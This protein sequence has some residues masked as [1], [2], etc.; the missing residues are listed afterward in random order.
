MRRFGLLA[1]LVCL[2]VPAAQAAPITIAFT[3][4]VTKDPF[5]F[6]SLGA[7]ISGTYTYDPA[8]PDTDAAVS[9]G[10]YTSVGSLYGFHVVV[11]GI[12]FNVAGSVEIDVSNDTGGDAYGVITTLDDLT[13]VLTFV[14]FTQSALSSDALPATAPSLASYSVA[15]F[16][17]FADDAGFEGT[18]NSISCIAG[19]TTGGDGSTVPEPSAVALLALGAIALRTRRRGPSII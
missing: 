16:L 7:P 11:D 5:L 12:P 4:V 1:L 3:G 19:C 17:L 2:L 18:L 13:L 9:S 15:Q 10:T 8:A 6:G 14:D